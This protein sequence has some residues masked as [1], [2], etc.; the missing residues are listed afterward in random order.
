MIKA[1]VTEENK[2]KIFIFAV[3][4]TLGVYCFLNNYLFFPP[5]TLPFAYL[6]QAIPFIPEMIWFY[7]SMYFMMVVVFLQIKNIEVLN[8]AFY[9]YFYLQIS[10]FIVFFLYPIGYPR[11]QFPLIQ[12]VDAGTKF[13]VTFIRNSDAPYNCFPSLHVGSSFLCSLI[14]WHEHKLKSGIAFFWTALVTFSTMAT[15]QHYMVDAVG[16][17]IFAFA[18]YYVFFRWKKIAWPTPLRS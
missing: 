11:E 6:D 16:G 9:A 2:Y 8:R 10:A 14:L 15:K 13:L 7:V 4:F 5:H 12:E 18:N 3:A 1:F 17:V